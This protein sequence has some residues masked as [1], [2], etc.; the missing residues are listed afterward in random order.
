MLAESPLV[1]SIIKLAI[2]IRPNRG[3][4]YQ[5]LMK[6]RNKG[7]DPKKKLGV[8]QLFSL[9]FDVKLECYKSVLF[10]VFYERTLKI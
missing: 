8:T 1:E 7:S 9:L 4:Y 5:L 6:K 3:L 2:Q 10:L